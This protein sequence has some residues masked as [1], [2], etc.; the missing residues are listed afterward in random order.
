MQQ[1][2]S[3][4]EQEDPLRMMNRLPQKLM[5]SPKSPS[6]VRAMLL[7]MLSGSCLHSLPPSLQPELTQ[8]KNNN[9]YP[10]DRPV[11]FDSVEADRILEALQVFPPPN[12]WNE[13]MS[14]RPVVSNSRAIIASIGEAK[15]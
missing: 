5:M 7:V 10:F 15:S 9:I 13:D 4:Y 3:G 6:A 1:N 11:P 14:R 8:T 12:P 2:W